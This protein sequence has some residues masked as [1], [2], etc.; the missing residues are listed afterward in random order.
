MELYEAIYNRR[1]IRKFKSDPVPRETIEKLLH[2]AN[3]APSGENMQMWRFL[4]VTGE[5]YEKIMGIRV[6]NAPVVIIAYCKASKNFRKMNIESVSAAI[7]NI[8]L[9]AYTEGLGSCWMMMPILRKEKMIEGFEIPEKSELIAAIPI[10]YPDGDGNAIKFK[11]KDPD[12][13]KIV[14]WIGFNDD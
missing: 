12:L 1:S 4:V 9:A 3:W 7:Q 11:R 13:S 10:G 8:V 2:A 6:F 5:E 14:K